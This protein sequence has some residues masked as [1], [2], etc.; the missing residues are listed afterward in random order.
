MSSQFVVHS[1]VGCTYCDM[2][3]ALLRSKGIAF[4]EIVYDKSSPNYNT[5]ATAL[6]KSTNHKT[7]PQIF[8]ER[9]FIG[10]YT[11]LAAKLK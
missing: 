7:F 3:K 11:E 2:A 10:G 9:T 6:I 1:L 4:K 8:C 5:K